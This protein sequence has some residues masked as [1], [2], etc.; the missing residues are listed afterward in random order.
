MTTVNNSVLLSVLLK[1][2]WPPDKHRPAV[3]GVQPAFDVTEM[4]ELGKSISIQDNFK[5]C[6][7]IAALIS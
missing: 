7:N 2:P 6:V 5:T 3:N 1:I 4:F